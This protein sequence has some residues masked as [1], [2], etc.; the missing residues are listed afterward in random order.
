M[1]VKKM[2]VKTEHIIKSLMIS[3]KTYETPTCDMIQIGTITGFLVESQGIDPWTP[4]SDDLID[5]IN[6]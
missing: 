1:T 5:D 3:K 2:K 4:D 6:F